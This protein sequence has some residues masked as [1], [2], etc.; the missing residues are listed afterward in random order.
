MSKSTANS[1]PTAKPRGKPFPKGVSGNPAGR[2]KDGQS[3]SAIIKEVGD[4]YPADILAMIGKTNDLGKVIAQLPS[5]VQ[6]KYLVTARVY[7]ALMFEPTQGLFKELMDRAE[8]KVKEQVDLTSNGQSIQLSD[9][10]RTTRLAELL[11]A[12]RA[13]RAGQPANPGEDTLPAGTEET[14]RTP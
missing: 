4:M 2:P 3:W 8:G 6:M 1:K 13:R 12:A 7:A 14:D 9:D 5:N 11:D 10:E